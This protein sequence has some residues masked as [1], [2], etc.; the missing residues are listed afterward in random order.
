MP[1]VSW[2]NFRLHTSGVSMNTLTPE[3]DF[4][5]FLITLT[6]RWLVALG[7]TDPSMLG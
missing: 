6:P 4:D 5:F 7:T 3:Q 1:V 2:S